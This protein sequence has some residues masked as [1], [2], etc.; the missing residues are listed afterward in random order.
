MRATIMGDPVATTPLD[1]AVVGTVEGAV[2]GVLAEAIAT[3][4]THTMRRTRFWNCIF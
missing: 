4:I 3:A 2:V 1:G